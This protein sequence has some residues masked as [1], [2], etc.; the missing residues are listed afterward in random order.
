MHKQWCPV[1]PDSY[2][3]SDFLLGCDVLDQAPFTYKK[4]KTLVWAGCTYVVSYARSVRGQ[5]SRVRACATEPFSSAQSTP[6]IN[7]ISPVKLGAHQTKFLI[8]TIKEIPGTTLIIYPQPLTSH[9]GHPCLVQVNG[10]NSI[11]IPVTNPSKKEKILKRDTCLGSYE[12]VEQPPSLA[13]RTTREIHN[14]LLPHS[15]SVVQHG[16][17]VQR[18]DKII[19]QLNLEHLSQ[20]ERQELGDVIRRY[21]ALFILDNHELGLISGQHQGKRLS[22]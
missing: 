19:S 7:L 16:I 21:D 17:R 11:H 14:D 6:H 12:K 20:R 18:L 5:V 2:M 3:T 22:A 4:Q 15:D 10:E 9:N 1:V 8:V 13:I